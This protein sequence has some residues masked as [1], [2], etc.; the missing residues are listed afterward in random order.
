MRICYMCNIIYIYIKFYILRKRITETEK[1][2][3]PYF[4]AGNSVKSPFKHL[5]FYPTIY[6][7]NS[8]DKEVVRFSYFYK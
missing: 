3:K 2:N 6:M 8:V 4:N 1:W 5:S 7:Y